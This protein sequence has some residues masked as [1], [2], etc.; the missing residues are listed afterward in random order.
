[1][2]ISSDIREKFCFVRLQIFS[3]TIC[4]YSMKPEKPLFWC[5][6]SN[7]IRESGFI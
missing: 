5:D 7:E 6:F 1:M 4:I 2:C 3:L